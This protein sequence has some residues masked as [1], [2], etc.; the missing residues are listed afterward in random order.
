[1]NW[2]R[3]NGDSQ[4]WTLT[5]VHD[6]S[7]T[8]INS[9]SQ[10]RTHGPAHEILTMSGAEVPGGN[11]TLAHDVKGNMTTD[12][13]GCIMTWDFDNMLATFDE[14]GVSGL[15]DATY[16]YDAIGRRIA[17]TVTDTGA[18]TTVFVQAGQQVVCE[19]DVPATGSPTVNVKEVYGSYIDEPLLHVDNTGTS[20]V[21]YWFHR[22]R[23]YSIYGL[24][25]GTGAVEEFYRYDPYGE[26]E[27]FS[28]TGT[29]RGT[30]PMAAHT[31]TFT[32]RGWD[33][34]SELLYFRARL[35]YPQQGVFL[36]RDPRRYH[37]GCNLF[38]A[39]F[40]PSHID[41]TGR[42]IVSCLR[43]HD[44]RHILVYK[45]VPDSFKGDAC[46]PD[47]NVQ[48]DTGGP[49]W[50]A[51]CTDGCGCDKKQCQ[52]DLVI[53]LNVFER[54]KIDNYPEA[55]IDAWLEGVFD[56]SGQGGSCHAWKFKMVDLIGSVDNDGCLFL[57]TETIPADGSDDDGDV[58]H[59]FVLVKNGCSDQCLIFDNGGFASTIDGLV[60]P[61]NPCT[62]TRLPLPIFGDASNEQWQKIRAQCGCKSTE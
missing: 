24:T 3:S 61:F 15:S 5:A 36:G 52:R 32:G 30:T 10:T 16:E 60:S 29:S 9:A 2:S 48:K 4:T 20:P 28:P 27:C 1:V 40:V 46:R 62:V 7:S 56:S 47:D 12:E 37:D 11:S 53:I 55:L 8:V 21:L 57:S 59:G 31:T 19:Y 44:S 54:I 58:D 6:W 41:P 33:A 34:E 39:Y 26:H 13:R 38:R 25:D 49:K 17:K 23:Q 18:V 50:S 43:R 45:Y 22:N 35:L 42:R 14:N 51:F